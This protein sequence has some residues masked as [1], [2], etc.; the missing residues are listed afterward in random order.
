M[1][2]D[3]DAAGLVRELDS[4]PDRPRLGLNRERGYTLVPTRTGTARSA[5][6]KQKPSIMLLSG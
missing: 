1:L 6:V 2:E 5:C 3:K 4:E